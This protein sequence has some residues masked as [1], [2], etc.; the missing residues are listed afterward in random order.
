MRAKIGNYKYFFGPYQI[1]DWLEHFCVLER[2]RE[3]I[4]DWLAETWVNGFCEW[5]YNKRKRKISIKLDRWDHWNADKT[6]S[7]LILPILKNLRIHKHGAGMVADEDVPE[8][9]RSTSAPPKQNEWDLDDNHF[10]R[11][12][13]MLDEVIWALEQMQPNNDWEEQFHSG[14]IDTF[15]EKIEGSV[16]S[17]LKHGPNHT[18]KFDVEGYRAY[19]NRIDNGLRLMGT[20]WRT[21]WD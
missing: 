14:N 16:C 15:F 5:I 8:E 9:F 21:F 3:R 7:I 10:K 20:Y 11:Y 19:S 2:D 12:E 13:W 18:H 17:E 6:M 1:A 4:G